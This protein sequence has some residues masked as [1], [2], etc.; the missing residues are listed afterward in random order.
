VNRNC[1]I[2]TATK[3]L[4]RKWTL[5]MIYYL[6]ERQRFCEL[7]ERVGGVNPATLSKRLRTLERAGI[8]KRHPISDAPRHVE[9]DL[10]DKGEDLLSI[11]YALA[12]WVQ[13]WY[14]EQPNGELPQRFERFSTKYTEEYTKEREENE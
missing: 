8:I 10:T 7:Q 5:E 11:L 4:S 1:P 2:S 13:R 9:Y 12:E 6:H 14:P 3:V